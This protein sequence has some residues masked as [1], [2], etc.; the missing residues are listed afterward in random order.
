[1]SAIDAVKENAA[2]KASAISPDLLPV[3]RSKAAEIKFG[4]ARRVF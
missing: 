1:M 2:L 4:R 3:L